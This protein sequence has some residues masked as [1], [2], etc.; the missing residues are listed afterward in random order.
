M[1]ERTLGYLLDLL[2]DDLDAHRRLVVTVT[3]LPP[4]RISLIRRRGVLALILDSLFWLRE[5]EKFGK[6]ADCLFV[7][8]GQP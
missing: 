5:C 6:A 8:L 2:C 1:D 3:R 4:E 7:L